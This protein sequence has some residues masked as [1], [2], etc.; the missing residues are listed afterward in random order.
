MI[1]TGDMEATMAWIRGR[2]FITLVFAVTLAGSVALI[3]ASHI[4]FAA[5][6]G[7][8][9]LGLFVPVLVCVLLHVAGHRGHSEQSPELGRAASS[10]Q[11]TRA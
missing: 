1:R 11:G 10:R 8:A 3:V 2:W 5:P 7:L 9:R 6:E 4:G